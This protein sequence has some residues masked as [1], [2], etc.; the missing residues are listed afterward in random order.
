[1]NAAKSVLCEFHYGHPKKDTLMD[2]FLSATDLNDHPQIDM[3]L[4]KKLQNLTDLL[5]TAKGMDPAIDIESNRRVFFLRKLRKNLQYF[6]YGSR[7]LAHPKKYLDMVFLLGTTANK[8]KTEV[9]FQLLL[10]CN[11]SASCKHHVENFSRISL[12]FRRISNATTQQ[13][14]NK[15]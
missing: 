10:M 12:V 8:R 13:I 6:I 9:G 3:I 5:E 7:R 2:A 1:M 14:L 15:K 11:Q 4:R